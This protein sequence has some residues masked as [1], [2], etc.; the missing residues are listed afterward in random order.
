MN[1]MN[2]HMYAFFT[3]KMRGF[4]K[5]GSCNW[6]VPYLPFSGSV[7]TWFLASSDMSDGPIHWSGT[8]YGPLEYTAKAWAVNDDGELEFTALSIQSE[9]VTLPC[10]SFRLP[11][12][13]V[14]K[15]GSHDQSELL[16]EESL[17][18]QIWSQMSPL[19][20]FR[21]MAGYCPMDTDTQHWDSFFLEHEDD[22]QILL[23]ALA[24]QSFH[25]A[26]RYVPPLRSNFTGII[27]GQAAH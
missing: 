1:I 9:S 17:R 25:T 7:S 27:Q 20:V 19:V 24:H 6:T 22:R 23:S 3:A 2:M 11:H 15:L 10:V 12:K 26:R 16:L 4:P 18:L 5:V 21:L 14:G 8:I 13:A